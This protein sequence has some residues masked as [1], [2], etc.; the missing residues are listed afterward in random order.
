MPGNIVHLISDHLLKFAILEGFIPS[1]LPHKSKVF[2]HNFNN[3]TNKKLKED[4]NEI[5][6][7]NKIYKDGENVINVM[8]LK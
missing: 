7:H 5:D 6:W 4:L 1:L 2:E 3:F 8:Y